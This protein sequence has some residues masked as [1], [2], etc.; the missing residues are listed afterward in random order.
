MTTRSAVSRVTV[1]A[2]AVGLLA[3]LPAWAPPLAGAQMNDPL[4]VEWQSR[5]SGGQTLISGYVYNHHLMRVQRVR[6][7]VEPSSGPDGARTVYLT[8]TIPSQGREY[9][10]VRVPAGGAPYQVTVGLFDWFGC[11]DG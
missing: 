8:G 7:R 5:D 9:F 4:R 10:E 3:G 2:L 6:L 11:G 1:V